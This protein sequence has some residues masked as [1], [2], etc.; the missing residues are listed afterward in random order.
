MRYILDDGHSRGS[1]VNEVFIMHEWMTILRLIHLM[2]ML[3][4]VP[5]L[6]TLKSE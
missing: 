4:H 1:V 5:P 6:L 3:V 2:N